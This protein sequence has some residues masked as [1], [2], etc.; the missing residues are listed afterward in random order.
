MPKMHKATW[1]IEL[2]TQ[3]EK[4]LNVRIHDIEYMRR[5]YALQFILA[6]RMSIDDSKHGVIL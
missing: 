1:T 4:K 6:H 5:V 2:E 3:I